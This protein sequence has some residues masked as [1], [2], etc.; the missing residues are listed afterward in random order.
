MYC[1]LSQGIG[2][3]GLLAAGSACG[4][5]TVWGMRARASSRK[6][7]LVWVPTQLQEASD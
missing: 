3:T 4:G 5:Q 6:H 2:L 7:R 1:D